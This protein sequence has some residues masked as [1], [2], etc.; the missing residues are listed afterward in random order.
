MAL[1]PELRE[2]AETFDRFSHVAAG[3]SVERFADERVCVLQGP[4]WASIS[5]VSVAADEVEAL[6]SEV[7]ER[8]PEGRDRVWWI[9]PST[10]PADLDERLREL[11]FREPGD[12]APLL[13]ALALVVA[14]AGVDG[15]EV[16]RI[17]T[18]E[19]SEAARELQWDAFGTP[20]ERR[21]RNRAR[22]REDFEEAQRVGSPVGFLALL[23]GRPAGTASAVPSARGMFLLGGSTAPWAGGR[24]VYRAL[25]R[26]RWDA[27]VARGTPALVVAAMPDTSYPILRRLGFEDVCE[28][29]RLEDQP[30]SSRIRAAARASASSS[31]R[32]GVAFATSWSGPFRSSLPAAALTA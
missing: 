10:R 32:Y 19:Q 15:I 20:E 8:V 1:P 22:S 25:V 23:D 21:A 27:A 13:R 2:Y 14:P 17:E 24:G 7:R 12:R 31:K 30:A 6:V 29:R 9:G 4:T 28:L 3:G 18:L 5:G 16:L 11:G 26:A